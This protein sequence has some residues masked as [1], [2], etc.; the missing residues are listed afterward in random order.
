MER[1]AGEEGFQKNQALKGEDERRSKI[2]RCSVFRKEI[3]WVESQILSNVMVDHLLLKSY[4]SGT[5]P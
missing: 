1:I 3:A 4:I 2:L 5:I